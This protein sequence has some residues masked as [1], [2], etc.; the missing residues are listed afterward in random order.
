[1]NYCKT[2]AEDDSWQTGGEVLVG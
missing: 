1:V 2:F